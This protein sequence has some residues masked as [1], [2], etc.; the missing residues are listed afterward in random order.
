[1]WATPPGAAAELRGWPHRILCFSLHF[2]TFA[3]IFKQIVN[4]GTLTAKYFRLCG[5]NCVLYMTL[6]LPK[7]II[8]SFELVLFLY[9]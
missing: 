6:L 5:V 1:M 4:I 7:I 2:H 8:S 9:F 3:C